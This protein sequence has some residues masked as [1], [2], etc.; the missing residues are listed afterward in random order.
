MPHR[1]Q[2]LKPKMRRQGAAVDAAG[3]KP[4]LSYDSSSDIIMFKEE[5]WTAIVLGWLKT[6]I[7]FTLS[8]ALI[9]GILY[10]ILAGTLLFF[11]PVSGQLALVARG[12]F[13]GG[14]PSAGEVILASNDIPASTDPLSK[15]KDGTFGVPNSIV[16][17]V[18]GAPNSTVTQTGSGIR[19]DDGSEATGAVKF[20]E[21]SGNSVQLGDELAVQCVSGACTVGDIFII[22]TN[23]VYGEVRNVGDLNG[24]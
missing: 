1:I 12:T 14:D 3:Q 19:S 5:S 18:I 6:S 7:M 10:I 16:V 24:K 13:L 15:I 23:L 8:A 9:M 21:G 20:P 2:N 4:A 22:N 17:K 11:T